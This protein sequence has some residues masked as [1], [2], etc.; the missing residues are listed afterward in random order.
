M[1][2]RRLAKELKGAVDILSDPMSPVRRPL[3]YSN[4]YRDLAFIISDE[5]R[6]ES[7]FVVEEGSESNFVL[8]DLGSKRV[9]WLKS[10]K[11]SLKGE[12]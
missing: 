1:T 3:D 5:S 4:A 11:D 12:S 6:W 2:A 10:F 8:H 9:E 7:I